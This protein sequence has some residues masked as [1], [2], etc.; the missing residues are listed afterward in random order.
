MKTG[1]IDIIIYL[2]Q[3]YLKQRYYPRY[4]KKINIII[5]KKL[6]KGDYLKLKLYKFIVL[7]DIFNKAL[8][9]V[10]SKKLNNIT[11]E[12]KLLLL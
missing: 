2:F 10:I 7:L 8:E 11:E 4:F 1:V 9:V 3:V 6:K 12:Y 5:F